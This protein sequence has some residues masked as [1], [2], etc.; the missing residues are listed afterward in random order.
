MPRGVP[1]NGFRLTKKRLASGKFIKDTKLADA[2]K[3]VMAV[4]A[5]EK[6]V[7]PEVTVETDEQIRTKL[8]DRFNALDQMAKAT[9]GGTNKTLIVSGP[10]GLGKSYGVMKVAAEEE[11]GGRRVEVIKGFVRPTGLYKVLYE[12]RHKNCTVIF[13]DADSVFN[14]DVSMNILKSA[15]DMTRTRHIHWRAETKMEDEGGERLPNKYEFEGS[16]IFITNYDFDAFIAK[17]NRL[18]P[19]FSAMIS[20]SIYLDLAMHS[21][22]DYMMRI[23]MVIEEGMLRDYGLSDFDAKELMVFVENNIE[24]LRELSLRMVIKIANLMRMDRNDWQRLAKVTF[25]T[26]TDRTKATA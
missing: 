26:N 1:K 4:T 7:E 13:D 23:N 22:R 21:R 3:D 19:H 14:D 16:I 5:A 6:V 25:F 24:R 20:R 12:N 9:V 11:K 17:G 15:C 8:T 10:A 18:S 2:V